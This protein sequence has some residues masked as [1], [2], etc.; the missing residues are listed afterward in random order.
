MEIDCVGKSSHISPDTITRTQ[1][2]TAVSSTSLRD[3]LGILATRRT[4][5]MRLRLSIGFR[6]LAL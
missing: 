1:S 4:A 2:R 6:K 3:W 5:I